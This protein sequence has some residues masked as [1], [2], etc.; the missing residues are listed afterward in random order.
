MILNIVSLVVTTFGVVITVFLFD[1]SVNNSRKIHLNE[2]IDNLLKV[3]NLFN[4]Y[5]PNEYKVRD[6]MQSDHIM[7]QIYNTIMKINYN[8]RNQVHHIGFSTKTEGDAKYHVY[9]S[10]K[11]LDNLEQDLAKSNIHGIKLLYEYFYGHNYFLQ[12]YDI[13]WAYIRPIRHFFTIVGMRPRFVLKKE[14]FKYGK[15]E[16]SP[17][18]KIIHNIGQFEEYVAECNTFKSPLHGKVTCNNLPDLVIKSQ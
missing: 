11:F 18:H 17:S 16:F 1:I 9:H 10:Q 2:I 12:H 14:S 8:T 7:D 5:I 6:I 13:R 4:S 15:F 3:F